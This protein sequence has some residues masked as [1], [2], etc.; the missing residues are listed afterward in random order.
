MISDNYPAMGLSCFSEGNSGNCGKDC[1]LFL[2]G[3]CDIPCEIL[4]VVDFSKDELY[5]FVDNY[6]TRKVI[7][8]Y[9]FL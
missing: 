9:L 7:K 3:E 2:S 6:V 1:R 5:D 8:T 4:E